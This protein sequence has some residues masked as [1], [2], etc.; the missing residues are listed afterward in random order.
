MAITITH[1]LC[2]DT[3]L[4]RPGPVLEF[5]KRRVVW[6]GGSMMRM[7]EIAGA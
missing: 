1:L 7:N 3:P 4:I 2:H 5:V 6:E